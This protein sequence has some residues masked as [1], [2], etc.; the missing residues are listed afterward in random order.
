MRSEFTIAL[1]YV[2]AIK[3]LSENLK[4][5]EHANLI[6]LGTLINFETFFIGWPR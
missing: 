2:K 4:N 3:S 5:D 1:N 6:N